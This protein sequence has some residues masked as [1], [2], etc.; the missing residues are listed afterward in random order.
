[1]RIGKLDQRIQIQQNTPTRD[2]TADEIDSWSEL[3]TVWAGVTPGSSTEKQQGQQELAQSIYDFLIRYRSDVTPLM[4]ILY[5]GNYYDIIS[6]DEVY[7]RKATMIKAKRNV[8]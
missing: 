2:D 5:E 1:M 8:A 6:A 7:R 4:R 3:D